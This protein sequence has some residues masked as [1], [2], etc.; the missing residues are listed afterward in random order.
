MI[1]GRGVK[2]RLAEQKDMATI[3]KIAQKNAEWLFWDGGALSL[4]NLGATLL[5]TAGDTSSKLWVVLIE[6]Q[7]KGFVSLNDINAIHRGA[8]IKY[9][10]LD[11]QTP[12]VFLD[13]VKTVLEFG[14]GTLN[15]HR[16][17]GMVYATHPVLHKLYKRA[18]FREEGRAIDSTLIRGKWMTL[19]QYALTE[20]EW[21]N[22]RRS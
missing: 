17:Y 12:W 19:V 7:V 14:F 1:S 9:I 3:Y 15:L 2:L 18:G 8:E 16:I 5:S 11:E 22:G 13:I 21:K 10:G 20:E 6:D 4:D